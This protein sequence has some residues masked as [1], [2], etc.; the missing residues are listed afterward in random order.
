MGDS[1][2]ESA[3]AMTVHKSQGSGFKIVIVPVHC[4]FHWNPRTETGLFSRELFY[5]GISRAEVALFTVGQW[6]AVETVV[7]RKTVG[8]RRTLLAG[9]LRDSFNAKEKAAEETTGTPRPGGGR[10]PDELEAL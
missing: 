1:H 10:T 4:L 7:G 8:Y 6:A 3:F 5:T 2:L 9:R